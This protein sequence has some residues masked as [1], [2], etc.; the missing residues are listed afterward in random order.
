MGLGGG[1]TRTHRPKLAK[2]VFYTVWHH[3]VTKRKE[4]SGELGRVGRRGGV[5]LLLLRDCLGISLQ[6]VSNCFVYHLLC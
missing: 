6:V 2:G 4:N 3:T 1:R 5:V